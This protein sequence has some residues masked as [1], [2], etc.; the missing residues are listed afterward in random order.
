MFPFK[1]HFVVSVLIGGLIAAT[2]PANACQLGQV[3]DSGKL[4]SSRRR[5]PNNGLRL[6]DSAAELQAVSSDNQRNLTDNVQR[7]IADNRYSLSDKTLDEPTTQRK[8]TDNLRRLSDSSQQ[9]SGAG[10]RRSDSSDLRILSSRRVL[11]DAKISNLHVSSTDADH[12]SPS[13]PVLSAIQGGPVK[14]SMGEHKTTQIASVAQL[15]NKTGN[16]VIG[17]GTIPDRNLNRQITFVNPQEPDSVNPKS[18]GA[19]VLSLST[20]RSFRNPSSFETDISIS[21]PNFVDP[22]SFRVRG[23]SKDSGVSRSLS[24]DSIQYSMPNAAP[25]NIPNGGRIQNASTRRGSWHRLNQDDDVSTD[26]LPIDSS[27]MEPADTATSRSFSDTTATEDDGVD[28]VELGR[29]NLD[30]SAAALPPIGDVAQSLGYDPLTRAFGSHSIGDPYVAN[31]SIAPEYRADATGKTKTWRTPNLKHRPLY[32]E[33]AA[34]E[35]HG[36]S[37]PKLQPIVSG[38]RFFSSVVLLPQKVL[39]TS[40]RECIHSV[41]Y[42]RPG[43]FSKNVRETLPRRGE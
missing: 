5:P 3:L 39:A 25:S 34:L 20:R 43:D 18:V 12:P 36:Q 1:I 7:T 26:L 10:V 6:L 23:E 30:D 2:A 38:A 37:L 24:S 8:L 11:S 14:R 41:G 27:A 13:Q 40:P 21:K 29:V 28:L 19:S 15:K 9:G 33:D 17:S 35:R 22:E 42:G 32:F 4:V 16:A 31:R